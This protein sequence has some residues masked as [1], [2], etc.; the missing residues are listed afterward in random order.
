MS[1]ELPINQF[2]RGDNLPLL[3]EIPSNSIRLVYIDPPF[4]TGKNQV[5]TTLKTKS[6]DASDKS[7]SRIGYQGKHYRQEVVSKLEYS[8]KFEDYMEFLRP[9]LQ[10]I[11]RILV[12]DGSLFLHIDWREASRCRMLLEEV[13]GGAKHCI[14]EIIWA[15]DFGART[16]AKWST[17]HDNIYW[18]AKDPNKYVYNH[19]SAVRIPYMAPGL[20]GEERAKK[21]KIPTDVWWHTI[22][23]TNGS[24]KTGYPTQKPIDLIKWIIAVHSDKSDVVLD[25]FAGS[26]TT[27][28]AAAQLGRGYILMDQSESS[29]QIVENR[30]PVKSETVTSRVL[31][32]FNSEI[33][34][35]KDSVRLDRQSQWFGSE[36]AW[37]LELPPASQIKIAKKTINALLENIS[38]TKDQYSSAEHSEKE[39]FGNENSILRKQEFQQA[40]MNKNNGQK[41]LKIEHKLSFSFNT[42]FVFDDVQLKS[43]FVAL[44]GLTSQ[45]VFFW[46]IPN[47]VYN[48]LAI[49]VMPDRKILYIDL[50]H[51]DALN[52]FG[53]NIN[54]SAFE[55]KIADIM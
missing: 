6:V 4:N 29:R 42:S 53:G 2:L 35:Q 26:G 10:Q 3:K 55:Q 41:G 21:G 1:P 5:K 43:D 12:D 40:G 47:G 18:F 51:S 44:L 30:L 19:E 28:D 15:Y 39:S 8:D 16:K 49:P 31:K 50:K 34:I 14:N 37:L 23:A 13:F 38:N 48:K 17:K 22:V 33:W 27:G 45:Q 11:H 46:L 54:D 9:R 20:V 52:V 7:S 36:Y 25:C 32:Q 24:E